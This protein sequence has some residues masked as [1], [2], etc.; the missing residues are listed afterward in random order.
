MKGEMRETWLVFTRDGAGHAIYTEAIDLGRIGR[1]SV[2]RA[3]TIEFDNSIQYWRVKDRTGFTMF[4]SPSR[5]ECLEWERWYLE[6]QESMKHEL[7]TG[8]GAV[9]AGA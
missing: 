3:T 2:R 1:L 9:A 4:N 6:S 7:P 5:Q 8:A